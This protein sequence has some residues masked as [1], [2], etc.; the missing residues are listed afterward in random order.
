MTRLLSTFS[1]K[2]SIPICLW[3]KNGLSASSSKVNPCIG[4]VTVLISE[5]VDLNIGMTDNSIL[6]VYHPQARERYAHCSNLEKVCKE[7][8]DPY[9]KL[10]QSVRQTNGKDIRDLIDHHLSCRRFNSFKLSS[11][12]WVQEIVQVT[13]QA[14]N[15]MAGSLLKKRLMA[16]AYRCILIDAPS[17]S[18]GFLGSF[19]HIHALKCLSNMYDMHSRATDYT[20]MYGGFPDKGILPQNIV[21]CLKADT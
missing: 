13:L 10:N 15:T 18:C 4:K 5:L 19:S 7:L 21:S 1:K 9:L 11:P 6:Q 2:C 14:F 8:Q 3:N 12:S 17:N 16:N 20:S